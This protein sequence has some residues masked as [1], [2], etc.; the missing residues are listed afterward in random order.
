MAV[1]IGTVGGGSVCGWHGPALFAGQCLQKAK[2]SFGGVR[3]CGLTEAFFIN[4]KCEQ[5]CPQY[6]KLLW[7]GK[8]SA[9]GVYDLRNVLKVDDPVAHA[10]AA[11]QITGKQVTQGRIDGRLSSEGIHDRRNVHELHAAF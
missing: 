10:P 11:T 4:P 2:Q 3:L 9:K 1:G 8:H 7:T 6:C 5:L